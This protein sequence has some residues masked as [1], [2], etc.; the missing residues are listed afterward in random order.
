VG[1]S[2]RGAGRSGVVVVVVVVAAGPLREVGAGLVI[3]DGGI[4]G[5]R[6]VLLVGCELLVAGEGDVGGCLEEL[7]PEL[8]EREEDRRGQSALP[9]MLCDWGWSVYL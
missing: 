7:L 6:G 3:V 1:L 2:G 9:A 8:E 5:R 4:L